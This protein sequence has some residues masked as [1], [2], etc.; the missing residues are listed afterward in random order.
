MTQFVFSPA[1]ESAPAAE[2]PFDFPPQPQTMSPDE[3]PCAAQPGTSAL[4]EVCYNELLDPNNGTDATAVLN[5]LLDM[6]GL[7]DMIPDMSFPPTMPSGFEQGRDANMDMNFNQ[8]VGS[9]TQDFS[10]YNDLQFNMLV[11]ENQTPQS[12]AQGSPSSMVQVKTEEEL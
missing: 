10:H 6:P 1:A 2:Q 12:E 11:N 8:N 4:G 3:R 5:Q 7:W 9:Y